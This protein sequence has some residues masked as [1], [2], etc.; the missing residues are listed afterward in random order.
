MAIQTPEIFVPALKGRDR[1]IV[2][3]VWLGRDVQYRTDEGVT[4]SAVDHQKFYPPALAEL[5]HAF[6]DK[7]PDGSFVSPYYG[8]SVLSKRGLGEWTS[9]FLL[10]GKEAIE[11]P[12]EVSYNGRLW[13]AKGGKRTKVELPPWGW[14]LEYDKPTG[15][16]SR[17]SKNKEDAENPPQKKRAGKE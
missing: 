11:R 6:F 15:F 4:L 16:P 9:T 10:D 12:E 17:T 14:A 13:V 7:N 1:V 3:Q 5:S 2:P 8:L